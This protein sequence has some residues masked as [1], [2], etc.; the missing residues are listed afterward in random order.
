M[1]TMAALGVLIAFMV[2]VL[3]KTAVVVPQRK[4]YVVERLGKYKKNT[5][6]RFSYPHPVF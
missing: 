6:G 1:N 5:A 2:V 3:W 4:E